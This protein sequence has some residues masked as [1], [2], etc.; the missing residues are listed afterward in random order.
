MHVWRVVL[1]NLPGILHCFSAGRGR[2]TQ[3]LVAENKNLKCCVKTMERGES[4]EYR[5]EADKNINININIVLQYRADISQLN[6]Y[7]SSQFNWSEDA[8]RYPDSDHKT[9]WPSLS[10]LKPKP[11]P[12]NNVQVYYIEEPVLPVCQYIEWRLACVIII[13]SGSNSVMW[14]EREGRRGLFLL[15]VG[16]QVTHRKQGCESLHSKNIFNE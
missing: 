1:H 15:F 16:S 10:T 14:G 13:S 11:N 6:Y 4:R 8:G 7:S 12:L 5:L 9:D 2:Q 3:F